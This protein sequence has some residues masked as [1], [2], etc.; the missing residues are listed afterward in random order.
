MLF[1]SKIVQ[2]AFDWPSV[3]S[4]ANAR[5]VWSPHPLP[6]AA[7]ALHTI[8]GVTVTYASGLSLCTAGSANVAS[9]TFTQDMG[10]L[11]ELII[12]LNSLTVCMCMCMCVCMSALASPGPWSGH[13]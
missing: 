7:Q 8:H 4:C 12:N 6:L 13:V 9:I 2:V 3:H 5:H 10:N 11:P 1:C